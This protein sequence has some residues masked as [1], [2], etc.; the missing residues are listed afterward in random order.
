MK[1]LN[2]VRPFLLMAVTAGLAACSTTDKHET[3]PNENPELSKAQSE[4]NGDIERSTANF[5]DR[6]GR[7]RPGGRPGWDRDDRGRPGGRDGRWRDGRRSGFGRDGRGFRGGGWGHHRDRARSIGYTRIEDG[8]DFDSVPINGLRIDAIMVCAAGDSVR[9]DRFEIV[10][11]NKERQFVDFGRRDL[12]GGTCTD[13]IDLKGQDRNV[14]AINLRGSSGWDPY[15]RDTAVEIYGRDNPN[16]G[17]GRDDRD[18]RNYRGPR[19]ADAGTQC[20]PNHGGAMPWGYNNVCPDTSSW[21]GVIG[22]PC[23]KVG[24]RCYGADRGTYDGECRD[25]N[26]N[27]NWGRHRNFNVYK[28]Q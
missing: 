17:G 23:A 4:E 21:G 5:G 16:W 2:I 14:V 18:D 10:F 19:W 20:G 7:G 1:V 28:C 15:G 9:F 27:N 13:W 24:D 12:E 26:G 8:Y 22:K 25:F 11:G 6:D 3:T